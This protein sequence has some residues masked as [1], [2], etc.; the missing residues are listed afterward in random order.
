M[1]ILHA[2]CVIR[3]EARGRWLELL[4]AVTPPSRT[5]DA[6]QSYVVHESIETPNTFT[7]VEEWASLDGLYAHF[8]TPHFAAFFAGLPEVLAE[9]PV[10]SIS[11][12]SAAI[13]LDAGLAHVGI[14]G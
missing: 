6:C 7:F 11:E 2:V 3:P 9:P 14:G 10:G 5:E 12:V 13:T 4:D 8:Q 1:V